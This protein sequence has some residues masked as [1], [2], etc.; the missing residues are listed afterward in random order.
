MYIDGMKQDEINNI[1]SGIEEDFI[2]KDF[3]ISI[4][5]ETYSKPMTF[6]DGQ[7][8][9]R[10]EVLSRAINY[11]KNEF[12]GSKAYT[13]IKYNILDPENET[14]INHDLIFSYND[15]KMNEFINEVILTHNREVSEPKLQMTEYGVFEV[16]EGKEGREINEADLRKAVMDG[17]TNVGSIDKGIS[18]TSKITDT[19]YTEED[20]NKIDTKISGYT[21]TYATGSGRSKN[22]ELGAQRINGTFL[23]PGES[24]SLN[25]TV[26][27]RTRA[28]GYKTAPEY[29][30]GK[31]VDGVGGGICQVSTTVYG[32]QLRAGIL[33]TQRHPHSMTVS[34]APIGLDA[35]ISGDVAD[36]KFDNTYDYPIYIYTN[37][38]RGRLTVEFWS[39]SNATDGIRFEPKSYIQ[40]PLRANAYLYGYDEDGNRVYEKELGVSTYRP[41]IK[42]NQENQTNQ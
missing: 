33:P 14:G 38:S 10:N 21:T 13:L 26:L 6:F 41:K 5:G 24:F 11:K 18:I 9:N 28:N 30:N 35:A 40:S 31:V 7:L 29:R 27:P 39:N 22:V 17:L 23:M 19:K 12:W 15:E 1:I 37:A 8:T 32:A 36:L 42:E 34:Y 25:T 16:I 4:D 2:K 20:V 3:K